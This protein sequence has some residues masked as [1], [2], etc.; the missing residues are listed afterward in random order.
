M[1][2]KP[3]SKAE[4]KRM[5]INEH[6]PH[7]LI[8]LSTLR[9]YAALQEAG[10]LDVVENMMRIEQIEEEQAIEKCMK[11]YKAAVGKQAMFS[12]L[13][14]DLISPDNLSKL[15]DEFQQN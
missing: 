13:Y 3:K 5:L 15:F 11:I 10:Q 8:A 2:K 1:K 4:F 12:Q 9:Y 6:V 14:L 7:E